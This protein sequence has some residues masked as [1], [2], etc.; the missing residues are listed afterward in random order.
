MVRG[1][2]VA[3]DESLVVVS[4][5]GILEGGYSDCSDDQHL[6]VFLGPNAKMPFVHH[7]AEGGLIRRLTQER[8]K[9]SRHS[10]I[11]GG[12]VEGEKE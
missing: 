12:L 4:V 8:M 9:S 11:G 1:A 7:A 6:G 3:D 2:E 5:L 10:G